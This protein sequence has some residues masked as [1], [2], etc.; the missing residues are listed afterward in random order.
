[1]FNTYII[2]SYSQLIGNNVISF[3]EKKADECEEI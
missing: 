2:I 1:M 3:S